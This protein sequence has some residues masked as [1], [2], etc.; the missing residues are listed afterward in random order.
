VLVRR[1]N[2]M[3]IQTV[4]FAVHEVRHDD[5]PMTGCG[6]TDSARFIFHIG[7]LAFLFGRHEGRTL[8]VEFFTT[9]FLL[10]F[11]LLQTR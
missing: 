2:P 5:P 11:R 8:V 1:S 10:R 7:R 9:G 4:D 6:Y 3:R